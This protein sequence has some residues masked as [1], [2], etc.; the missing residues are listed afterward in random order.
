[1]DL[2]GRP[3][4]LNKHTHLSTWDAAALRRTSAKASVGYLPV[5]EIR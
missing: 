1:M 4:V 5:G 2:R 3:V